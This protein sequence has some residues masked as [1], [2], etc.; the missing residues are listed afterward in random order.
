MHRAR[1]NTSQLKSGQAMYAVVQLS[2]LYCCNEEEKKKL[3]VFI[4]EESLLALNYR[5]RNIGF[6]SVLNL[7]NPCP[8]YSTVFDF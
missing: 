5:E 1:D 4:R 3:C 7:K 6:K 2:V 8:R